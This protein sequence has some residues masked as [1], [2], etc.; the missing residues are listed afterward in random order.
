M[1]QYYKVVNLD[2]KEVL[3]PHK[4]GDGL[5][6]LEFGA[7]GSG[8][9]LGLAILLAVGNNRGGG[10]LYSDNPIIGSWSGNKIAIIGDYADD[11]DDWKGVTKTQEEYTEVYNALWGE[12]KNEKPEN[13]IEYKD[14]SKEVVTALA[15][16]EYIKQSFLENA[17]GSWGG[18][19]FSFLFT[20]EE[21]ATAKEKSV[22]TNSKIT[23]TEFLNW[24]GSDNLGT[25]DLAKLLVEIAN[26]E[27]TPEQLAK[28]VK[29]YA[30]GDK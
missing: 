4:F 19:N 17:T 12:S 23:E 9:M 13:I 3:H 29:V 30:E 15:D 14:I 18:E 27:Y 10:D 24:Q 7:S 6:L 16:D 11:S 2:K 8:T 21:L 26:G 25:G 5:K 20:P 1:G 22:E 28:D